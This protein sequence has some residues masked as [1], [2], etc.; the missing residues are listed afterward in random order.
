MND[1]ISHHYDIPFADRDGAVLTLDVHIGPGTG[2]LPV[3]IWIHGGGWALGD[4]R[5]GEEKIIWPYARTGLAVVSINYRLSDTATHPG[6]L[7]DAV[8]AIAWVREHAA[9]F[10]FDV[11]SIFVG[12]GSAGGH[13]AALIGLNPSFRG[14]VT[15]TV[16][17][18]VALYPVTD[19]IRWDAELIATS[20]RP[21]SFA[22]RSRE[23]RGG[24]L[25]YPGAKHL[26]GS[27]VLDPTPFLAASPIDSTRTPPFL[28][29]HGSNDSSVPV[30]HGIELY[31]HLVAAGAEA[32]LL[33]LSDGDHGSPLF[34]EG[35]ALQ[36]TRSLID[37]HRK[38]N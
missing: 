27:P 5:L 15:D 6:P 28:I 16:R 14:G 7:E 32:S 13:I 30:T 21:G 8:D 26:G 2:P 23:Q 37:T 12:G 24:P 36:A 9:D 38:K 29:L 18:I 4:S 20:P 34:H 1:T 22:E 17:G 3:L 25:L 35:V 10:P 33:L 19:P 31:E 11:D